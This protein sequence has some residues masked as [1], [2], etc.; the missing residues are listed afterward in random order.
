MLLINMF[1]VSSWCWFLYTI[2]NRNVNW[3]CILHELFS[4]RVQCLAKAARK[5]KQKQY[6]LSIVHS[7]ICVLSESL[8]LICKEATLNLVTS[9]A[10]AISSICKL[11]ITLDTSLI[12]AALSLSFESTVCI[13]R[14]FLNAIYKTLIKR[15]R[16]PSTKLR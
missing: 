9:I 6:L 3:C 15:M 16:M 11:R 13:N 4:S 5:R 1:M 12:F 2:L 7:T 14:L 8:C 10:R